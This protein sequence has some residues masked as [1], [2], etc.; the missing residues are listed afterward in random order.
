MRSDYEEADEQLGGKRAVIKHIIARSGDESG[1][2]LL[3]MVMYILI[4]SVMIGTA[5]YFFISMR[6]VSSVS[7]AAVEVKTVME[8]G[9][10]LAQ[11]QNQKVTLTFYGPGSLHPN[12]YSFEKADGTSEQPPM[13]SSYFTEGAVY[14]IEL[15][16]GSGVAISSTE[17]IEFDPQG[18]LMTITFDPDGSVTVNRSGK[19]KTVTINSNGDITY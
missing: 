7:N 13:G 6:D 3:E 14:Y 9:L 18:T 15:Q 5:T 1:F 12:T 16:E 4:L 11:T 19:S 8:R 17:I 10:N 2:T